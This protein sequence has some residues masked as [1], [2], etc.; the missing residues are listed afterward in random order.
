[1]SAKTPKSPEEGLTSSLRALS[2]KM[3]QTAGEILQSSL[4]AL[5]E[6]ETESEEECETP[7]RPPM[8]DTMSSVMSWQAAT[9]KLI[10]ASPEAVEEKKDELISLET[11]RKAIAAAR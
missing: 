6:P 11:A 7:K 4:E 3:H 5:Q 8:K 9:M 10:E 1:M 2:L